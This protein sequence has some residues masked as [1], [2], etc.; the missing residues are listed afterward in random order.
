MGNKADLL[1]LVVCVAAWG[2]AFY[3]LVLAW[4]IVTDDP[5][6]TQRATLVEITVE[7]TGRDVCGGENITCSNEYNT[8]AKWCVTRKKNER[9]LCSVDDRYFLAGSDADADMYAKRL[10]PTVGTKS[11]RKCYIHWKREELKCGYNDIPHWYPHFWKV[12][13]LV[14]ATII[15]F[16]WCLC[17]LDGIDE[18]GLPPRENCVS[19]RAEPVV[20][21]TRTYANVRNPRVTDITNNG[22]NTVPHTVQPSSFR[23]VELGQPLASCVA[24]EC[25]VCFESLAKSNLFTC[26]QC[27]K[28]SMHAS[29]VSTWVENGDRTCPLC[30][31]VIFSTQGPPPV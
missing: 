10:F 19:P 27:K 15:M 9:T 1:F 20:A 12:I 24:G 21:S 30:R 31:G 4:Q 6:T 26:T 13:G 5:W 16:I 25:A 3:G 14:F 7:D 11:E 18:S 22:N 2:G 8:A 23:D 17:I 28:Q 29:C